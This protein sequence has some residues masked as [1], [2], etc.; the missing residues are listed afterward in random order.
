MFKTRGLLTGIFLALV[1]VYSPVLE[2]QADQPAVAP[3][4]ETAADT[5]G[6]VLGRYT[7]DSGKTW[8]P[9]REQKGVAERIPSG[10]S[11]AEFMEAH[12]MTT[13]SEAAIVQQVPPVPIIVDGILYQPEEIHLFDGKQL[14][15]TVG[16]DGRL[17]AFTSF[18]ALEDFLA[19]DSRHEPDSLLSYNSMFYEDVGMA[20]DKQIGVAPGIS[21]PDLADMDNVISSM[22]ISPFAANDSMLFE[23]AG[24]QGLYFIGW[25][26]EPYPN[27][28]NVRLERPG[29]FVG[30]VAEV[31]ISFVGGESWNVSSSTSGTGADRC[32]GSSPSQGRKR[33]SSLTKLVARGT[34]H[35]AVCRAG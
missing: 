8:I 12:R 17:Y 5:Q 26:G 16:S 3:E 6:D 34:I 20:G 24:L 28:G 7:A 21:L 4:T 13:E 30:G 10:T 27:L 23:D 35:R 15:F 14:G 2:V 25:C 18:A 29:F 1:L 31:G 11:K 19:A 33:A 32:D 22:Q 9:I